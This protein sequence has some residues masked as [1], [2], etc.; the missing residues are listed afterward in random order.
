MIY[1]R[2][3]ESTGEIVGAFTSGQYPSHEDWVADGLNFIEAEDQEQW[4]SSY[5]DP[6]TKYITSAGVTER[7]PSTISIDTNSIG[8]DGTDTAL[9]SN[10]P[11]GALLT[12]VEVEDEDTFTYTVSGGTF[13]ITADLP[14]TMNITVE[15]DFPELPFTTTVVAT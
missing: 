15:S 9:I 5:D 4:E 8:A 14:Q 1:T 6:H 13:D 7:P 10:I 3:K 11:E 2:Y 12:L